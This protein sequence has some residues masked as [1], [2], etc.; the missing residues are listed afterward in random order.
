MTD[1][2][3]RFDVLD[4]LAPTELGRDIARRAGHP[5][6]APRPESPRRRLVAGTAAAAIFALVAVF[7]WSALRPLDAE[8][9]SE[10]STAPSDAVDP[11]V[12]VG[13]GFT[14]IP[15]PPEFRTGDVRVWTGTHLFTWGGNANHGDGPH[16]A[17]GWM[18]D[19][20]TMTWRDVSTSPL[21]AR[22]WAAGV[23]TGTEILVWGGAAGS[24][25]GE[26]QRGDGAAFDPAQDRWRRIAPSPI[27]P[28]APAVAVWTGSEAI[29]WGSME[30]GVVATGAAYDPTLDSWR[31]LPPAPD[32][33]AQA[34]VGTWTGEELVVLGGHGRRNEY[35]AASLGYDPAT[36]RWRSVIQ[37]ELDDNYL[38]MTTVGGTAYAV[39]TYRRVMKL[40]PGSDGW[41]PV[42]HAPTETC[43]GF[44]SLEPTDEAVVASICV[45]VVSLT[46]GTYRWHVPPDAPEMITQLYAGAGSVAIAMVHG[47]AEAGMARL[48]AYRPPQP[49]PTVS[50][51]DA[52]DLAT[53][54]AALRSN[55][56][57]GDGEVPPLVQADIDTMLSP[58]GLEAWQGGQLAPL[59]AYYIDF[60]VGPVEQRGE[61]FEARITLGAYGGPDADEVIVM[62]PG[63]DLGGTTRELVIVGAR[64]A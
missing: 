24:W 57:Y 23:W 38:D 21:S 9:Q 42:A 43:E 53:A 30:D 2:D 45:G 10:R 29:F 51:Q 56:P 7:A 26:R 48:V 32:D 54:F 12:A 13:P 63:A 18:L 5:E 47:D 58:E 35:R 49:D 40:E 55:Y 4:H 28:I 41:R 33:L 37:S 15:S 46:P 36:D 59:W 62:R 44:L 52:L 16:A 31:I 22:S 39:D 6:P 64:A 8:P 19:P 17:D 34:V 27:E 60:D 3:P 61:A 20:T 11:W 14:P 50:A 25:P 1:R